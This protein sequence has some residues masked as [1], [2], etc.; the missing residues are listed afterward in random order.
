[1]ENNTLQHHGILGMKWGVRRFQKKDGSLT[2]LGKKRRRDQGEEEEKKE[3]TVEEKRARLLKSTDAKE[4]Y[5]NRNLL[6]TNE[7]NDRIN[8]IDTEARLA[9]K[10]VTEKKTSGMDYVDKALKVGRK[11]NE[12]YEFTNTPVMKA[13]KKQLGGKVEEH[14]SPDL[15]TVWDNRDKMSDKTMADVLKRANTE[16][17]IKKMLDEQNDETAKTEALKKAQKEVDDYNKNH[18]IGSEKSSTY[19][20]S[21]DDIIDNKTGT[22]N[23]NENSRLR[24]ETS[25]RFEATG[26]DIFGEGNS[27]FTGW[28]SEGKD[29]VEGEFRELN[30]A[31]KQSDVQAGQNFV[32]GLLEDKSR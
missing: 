26:K 4:L 25:E 22:G 31:P 3:E 11:V 1:M 30:N 13:L 27:K 5:E 14:L 24:L 7:L 9:S 23:K 21:G 29:F 18:P 10:I 15:K 17:A 2:S 19:S 8:R 28:K 32:A 12:V 16:K 6:T 20:K